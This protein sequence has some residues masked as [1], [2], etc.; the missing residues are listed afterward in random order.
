M[1]R[2]K[3]FA[4]MFTVIICMPIIGFCFML[5]E[6][7]TISEIPGLII[8]AS[9][10]AIPVTLLFG[11][12]VSILSDKIND[13][14]IGIKRVFSSFAIHLLF[15]ISFPFFFMLL[16]DSRSIL[17]NFNWDDLYFLIPST[18]ISFVGWGMDEVL[19]IYFRN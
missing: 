5:I 17:T 8:F 19:R 15:G 11:V 1:F 16:A 7:S 10:Y 3:L 13:R 6:Q 14:L 2:R 18:L 9:M 12:P 4:F